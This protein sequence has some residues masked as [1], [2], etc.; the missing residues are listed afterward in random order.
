M[1]TNLSAS[2]S[3]EHGASAILADFL[4][5]LGAR[6]VHVLY[7][8]VNPDGATISAIVVGPSGVVVIDNRRWNGAVTV[9]GERLRV[10]GYSKPAVLAAVAESTD[11]VAR[12]VNAA[13][14]EARGV[15]EVRGVITFTTQ[16]DLALTTIGDLAIAGAA[17]LAEEL[18]SRQPVLSAVTVERLHGDLAVAFPP[19]GTVPTSSSGLSVVEETELGWFLSKTVT[20]YYARA[21]RNYSKRRVYLNDP[22]G[23]LIGYRDLDGEISVIEPGIDD[24]FARFVIDGL[25]T[26]GPHL[27]RHQIPKLAT[28]FPMARAFAVLGKLYRAALIGN[29]WQSRGRHLLY[30]TL[31]HPSEG[32]VNLGYV[33]LV[34]GFV[35]TEFEGEVLDGAATPEQLLAILRDNHPSTARQANG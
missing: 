17:T 23:Q 25:T 18:R 35:K 4:G 5:P 22:T 28:A 32:V 1:S 26:S 27:D 14:V 13:S 6:G 8:R 9:D 3:A 12:L 21:W 33:D 15:A 24:P 20:L 19:A 30:G 29:E 7:D 2:W 11:A 10:A 34:T 31:V 16:P